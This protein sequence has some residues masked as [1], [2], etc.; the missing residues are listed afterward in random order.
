MILEYKGHRP[1]IGKNVFIAPTATIIG[2]VE[3]KDG[4]SIWYGT[5][6]RGDMAPITVGKSTNI[7]DNCTIHT[8]FDKPTIIGDYVTVGHNA[9]VHG[10]II[11]N[12]CLIGINAVVLSNAFIKTGSVV[13]AGS[14]VKHGQVVGPYHLVAGTPA[15]IKKELS[16]SEMEKRKNTAEHYIELAVEHRAIKKAGQ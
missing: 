9:V 12:Y 8:D 1:K 14:V 2:N 16:E 10:C 7:Q 5:V 15:S 11:E 3:I 4:A 6:L 13:A